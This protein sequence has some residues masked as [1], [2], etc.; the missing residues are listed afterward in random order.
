MAMSWAESHKPAAAAHVH[1][2]LAGLMWTVVGATLAGFGARWLWQLPGRT[3]PWLV[4][5]VAIGVI[6]ARFVLDRAA[7]NIVERI[8]RRGDGRCVGGFMSVRSW[9]LVVVMMVA[10]RLLRGSDVARALLGVL[11]LAVGT[12][13]LLSSRIAWRAWH[14]HSRLFR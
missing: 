10:G 9:A 12:G 14:N 11:Y 4:I 2:L 3:A 1:L 13:L 5:A 8:C 6:K 7:R